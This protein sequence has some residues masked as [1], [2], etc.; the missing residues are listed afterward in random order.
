MSSQKRGLGRGLGALL[1]TGL[2]DSGTEQN[3]VQEILLTKIVPNPFQPRKTFSDESIAELA[4]SI[5]KNSL[6]QPI[7][8]RK[9]ALNYQIINGE[10]RFRA[11]QK[12]NRAQIPAIITDINDQEMLVWAIIE[13]I[14]RENLNPV[15]EA[16]SYQELAT[17]FGITHEQ[18]ATE[19]G[20]S[21]SYISNS[22]R[23][24]KLPKE[25]LSYLETGLISHGAARAI[26]A[27]DDTDQQIK[28]ALETIHQGWNVRQVEKH[29]KELN[30]SVQTNEKTTEKIK[31]EN[32]ISPEIQ[33][34]E[35]KLQKIL[36][37]SC[38]IVGK[39]T[40]KIEISFP[41]ETELANFVNYI[42]K[43]N[44]D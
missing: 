23:L 25:I 20:K 11:F 14:Q 9:T 36:H 41:N 16:I 26:L 22:L 34:Y 30:N 12:L 17:S 10:R 42:E 33:L 15:E 21:R 27:L 7:L 35:S 18:L 5:E 2:D 24:L 43:F 29:V 13:N 3:K 37:H 6:I 39:K 19:L 38:R 8:L 1:K 32:T 44:I 4:E 28:V 40:K 31:I